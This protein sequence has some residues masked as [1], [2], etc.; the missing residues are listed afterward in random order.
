MNLNIKER[1][2][3][4]KRVLQIARKPTAEEFLETARV[5]AIGVA[6][7]G[8]IAFTIYLIAVLVGL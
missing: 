7:I 8:V 4:Y 3:S 5:C 2:Q 1:L 6:I